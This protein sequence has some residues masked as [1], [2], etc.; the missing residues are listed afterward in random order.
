MSVRVIVHEPIRRMVKTGQVTLDWRGGTV[1]Q[2]IDELA[3]RYGPELKREL[4]DGDGNLDYTY[5]VFIN[6]VESSGVGAVVKDGDEVIVLS[7]ISGG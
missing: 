6:D 1:A 7:P 2:L 4:L 5:R 3:R